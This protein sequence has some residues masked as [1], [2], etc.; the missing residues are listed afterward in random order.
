MKENSFENIPFSTC[1]GGHIGLASD[2]KRVMV[3]V[4]SS[5]TTGEKKSC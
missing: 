4:A 2:S 3:A 5:N 1:L